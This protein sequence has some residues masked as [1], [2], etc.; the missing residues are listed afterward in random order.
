MTLHDTLSYRTRVCSEKQAP[1]RWNRVDSETSSAM[2]PRPPPGAKARTTS[3]SG[4]GSGGEETWGDGLNGD[5]REEGRGGSKYQGR[6][7]KRFDVEHVMPD[8]R[9]R[10]RS[11]ETGCLPWL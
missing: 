4:E 9:K 10:R 6:A 1:A 8:R 3:G 7:C 2:T 11:P 5:N